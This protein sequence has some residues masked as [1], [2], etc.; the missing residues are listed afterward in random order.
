MFKF[1]RIQSPIGIDYLRDKLILGETAETEDQLI[2]MLKG[3]L[4]GQP[5]RT[6]YMSVVDEDNIIAFILGYVPEGS[7]YAVVFQI[8]SLLSA[9]QQR[10]TLFMRFLLWC[11]QLEIEEVRMDDTRTSAEQQMKWGFKTCMTVRSLN[12][13]QGLESKLQNQTEI[14]DHK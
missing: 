2:E 8:W 11:E 12:V 5:L 7:K 3:I 4:L 10:D 1:I 14:G 9:E 6:F 13:T